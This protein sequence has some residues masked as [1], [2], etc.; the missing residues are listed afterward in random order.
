MFSKENNLCNLKMILF[1][2]CHWPIPLW[3]VYFILECDCKIFL[4][5]KFPSQ[6]KGYWQWL[7]LLVWLS[8]LRSPFPRPE[9]ECWSL[10]IPKTVPCPNFVVVIQSNFWDTFSSHS[11]YGPWTRNALSDI[12][13]TIKFSPFATRTSNLIRAQQHWGYFTPPALERLLRC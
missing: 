11:P 4:V 13:L 7:I 8:Y 9:R 1:V 3:S 6:F 10:P 2:G 12:V 5:R